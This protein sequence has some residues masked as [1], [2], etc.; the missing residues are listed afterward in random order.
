MAEGLMYLLGS[1][2]SYL[3]SMQTSY[4]HLLVRALNNELV[5]SDDTSRFY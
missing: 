5:L 2:V 4:S 3:Q 1:L